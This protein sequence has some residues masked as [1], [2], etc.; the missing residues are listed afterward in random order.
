MMVG[1]NSHRRLVMRCT[2]AVMRRMPA[3]LDIVMIKAEDWWRDLA[4]WSCHGVLRHIRTSWQSGRR[5]LYKSHPPLDLLSLASSSSSFGECN[6]HPLSSP[7]HKLISH[8]FQVSPFKPSN[9]QYA[10]PNNLH[11]AW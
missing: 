3:E 7:F 9:W 8:R 4:N 10:Y 5:E 1:C 2:T 11:I 6:L